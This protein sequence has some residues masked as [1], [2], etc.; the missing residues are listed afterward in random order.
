MQMWNICLCHEIIL[1]PLP[2]HL[3]EHIQHTVV[4]QLLCEEIGI[5]GVKFLPCSAKLDKQ[6]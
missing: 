1:L 5:T 4:E 6:F 2:L 3:S